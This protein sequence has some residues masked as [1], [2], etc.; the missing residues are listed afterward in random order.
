M[1]NNNQTAAA[2]RLIPGVIHDIRLENAVYHTETSRFGPD[3]R[4]HLH[5]TQNGKIITNL[6]QS[7]TALVASQDG[8]VLQS[9]SARNASRAAAAVAIRHIRAG[10]APVSIWDVTTFKNG[11]SHSETIH[12]GFD[13]VAYRDDSIGDERGMCEIEL[14]VS[15]IA[16]LDKMPYCETDVDGWQDANWDTHLS[17]IGTGA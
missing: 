11:G 12:H 1:L 16:L 17:H 13:H 6:F 2:D 9:V 4:E 8:S 15:E 3:G 14:S 7:G 10:N 5:M